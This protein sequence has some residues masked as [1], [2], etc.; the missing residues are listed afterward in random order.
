MKILKFAF[1]LL[2][3]VAFA[4]CENKKTRAEIEAEFEEYNDSSTDV[5]ITSAG[6]RSADVDG[7]NGLNGSLDDLKKEEAKRA[8][9]AN[10]NA[11][12][13]SATTVN[14][15]VESTINSDAS[16]SEY[17]AE[18]VPSEGTTQIG[19]TAAPVVKPAEPAQKPVETAPAARQQSVVQ[20]TEPGKRDVIV[21]GQAQ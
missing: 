13:A 8:E 12:A 5:N 1:L 20:K 2:L 21:D 6:K 11:S 9:Q 14:N 19:N 4:S 10:A 15:N 7:T 18:G 16:V 17:S 3:V